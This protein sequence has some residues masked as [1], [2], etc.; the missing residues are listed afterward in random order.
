VA[1]CP[2]LIDLDLEQWSISAPSRYKPPQSSTKTAVSKSSPPT[3]GLTRH[4]MPTRAAGATPTTGSM[5][6]RSSTTAACGNV[7]GLASRIWI[8]AASQ[9][10]MVGQAA[11]TGFNTAVCQIALA[12]GS[13]L[14]SPPTTAHHPAGDKP[15]EPFTKATIDRFQKGFQSCLQKARDWLQSQL[16]SCHWLLGNPSMAATPPLNRPQLTPTLPRRRRSL[17]TSSSL[18]TWT[19][20]P[21][22]CSGATAS[23]AVQCEGCN[24]TLKPHWSLPPAKCRE[25]NDRTPTS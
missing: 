11:R 10:E 2:L 5:G 21:R 6:K 20:R 8:A 23:G 14:Y 16:L 12:V 13:P 3:I 15:C 1:G 18:P 25:S 24:R 22:R 4:P 17:T 7:S 9:L 19:I